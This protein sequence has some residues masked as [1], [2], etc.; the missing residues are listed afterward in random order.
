MSDAVL[1]SIIVTV[2][3]GALFL[4]VQSAEK[5]FRSAGKYPL[6][7]YELKMLQKAGYS[8]SDSRKFIQADLE[9]FPSKLED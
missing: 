1:G 6:T 4:A 8:S 9:S 5:S 2:A 7:K 3:T